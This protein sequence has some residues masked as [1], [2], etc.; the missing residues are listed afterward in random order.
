M[1]KKELH[2][3]F[4]GHRKIYFM[5]SIALI[6]LSLL[7]SFVLNVK[8][9]IKFTGG[10]IAT[11]SYS[12][13]LDA[14]AFQKAVEDQTGMPVKLQ[15]STN[16]ATGEPN[17]ALNFSKTDGLPVE[18]QTALTDAL[19]AA[20]PDN[21]IA[22]V[23]TNSVSPTMG[24]DFLLK[25]L[26]TVSFCAIFMI[27]YIALRFKRISG[28]SA[29]VMAVI[30]LL[31][32][33]LMVYLAFV[34]FRLSLDDN[35]IAVLLVI[36]GYSVNDTI[37]IYDRIRENKK[38]YGKSMDT[39][40]MVNLSVNQTLPRT[41]NTTISTL[42]AMVTICV[43]ALIFQVNSILSFALPLVVGLVSGAYSSICLSPVLWVMWQNHKTAK[44][45]R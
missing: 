44:K 29:G 7:L 3:D 43:L 39:A 4:F 40:E 38:L 1:A 10:T 42:I 2:F 31:H 27:V 21:E 9:D 22:L 19:V 32:D 45:H 6:A 8:V 5:I 13:S 23:S 33:M 20:F 35:F 28:W 34:V 11:Y 18:E 17:L 25:C 16:I 15:Q 24:K 30:A 26:V 14:T 37:V 41:L 12:G 36:L